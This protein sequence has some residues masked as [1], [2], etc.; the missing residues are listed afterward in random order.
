MN[1]IIIIPYQFSPTQTHYHT[2]HKNNTHT[3]SC[4]PLAFP[5]SLFITLSFESLS[6]PF[7]N[8]FAL[9]RQ[10]RSE[11]QLLRYYTFPLLF[12]FLSWA[13]MLLMHVLFLTW[14]TL[15]SFD[16]C[17]DNGWYPL[18]L[19]SPS[20]RVFLI[21]FYLRRSSSCS[22][23]HWPFWWYS[24]FLISFFFLFLSVW[25]SLCA[26]LILSVLYF[27]ITI[28]WVVFG[29]EKKSLDFALWVVV[30]W[31]FSCLSLILLPAS[32][33]CLV[34]GKMQWYKIIKAWTLFFVDLTCQKKW[35]L[36]WS[37]VRALSF[38]ASILFCKLWLQESAIM[39]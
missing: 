22:C 15:L 9:Y 2:Q 24:L 12:L 21:L 33:H 26:G 3:H 13:S 25:W 10:S 27:T 14:T 37:D 23:Q 20:R 18:S 6:V 28:R 34:P 29:L 30:V 5:L 19:L 11:T 16:S 38:G 32:E 35:F 36:C 31:A 39:Q 8:G 4:A 7:F 17:N 1:I